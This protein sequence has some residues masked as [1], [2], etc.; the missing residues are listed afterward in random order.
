MFITVEEDEHAR[1]VL[2]KRALEYRGVELEVVVAESSADFKR[3]RED[4]ERNRVVARAV[5][6]GE[7][8]M[9]RLLDVSAAACSDLITSLHSLHSSADLPWDAILA[10]YASPL[11][12]SVRPPAL[13]MPVLSSL[14]TLVAGQSA[15]VDIDRR[16]DGSSGSGGS[17]DADG[18]WLIRRIFLA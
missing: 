9:E 6:V 1:A 18:V 5:G 12:R 16:A 14:S 2:E 8:G 13:S 4:E 11:P 3:T 15:W 17:R 10:T 7:D